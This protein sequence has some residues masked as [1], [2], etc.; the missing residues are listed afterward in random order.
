MPLYPSFPQQSH[1]R[2]WRERERGQASPANGQQRPPK[3]KSHRLTSG[4]QHIALGRKPA[5]LS[6]HNYFVKKQHNY[7]G[8][9]TSGTVKFMTAACREGTQAAVSIAGL[10]GAAQRVV[11]RPADGAYWQR[12][13]CPGLLWPPGAVSKSGRPSSGHRTGK[14]QSS[15]QFPR[16]VVLKNVITIR[17]LHSFP[18]LVRSCLKSCILDFRIR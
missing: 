4:Y 2:P 6:K 1:P 9:P 14:G 8:T 10:A 3:V 7:F 16:K 13:E 12:P 17:Q 11:L 18:M 5:S 15:T